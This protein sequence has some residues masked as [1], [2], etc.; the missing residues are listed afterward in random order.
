MKEY[1][2]RPQHSTAFIVA[3]RKRGGA[4]NEAQVSTF[5]IPDISV[6]DS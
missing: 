2:V 6:V 5:H 1:R 4:R 3:S